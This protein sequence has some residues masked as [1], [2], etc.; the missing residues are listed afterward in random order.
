MSSTARK[1]Y[2]EYAFRHHQSPNPVNAYLYLYNIHCLKQLIF[3]LIKI[4]PQIIIII[5]HHFRNPVHIFSSLPTPA[6]ATN[7]SSL[8]TSNATI[9]TRKLTF[10]YTAFKPLVCSSAN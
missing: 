9:T 5:T 4:T 3:F 8:G 7:L 1:V 6:A 10:V 2:A